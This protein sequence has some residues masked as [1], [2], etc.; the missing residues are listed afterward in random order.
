MAA[1]WASSRGCVAVSLAAPIYAHHVAHT[2]AFSSNLSG[3]TVINGKEVPILQQGGG[4]LHLGE[5]PI[6][7]TWHANYFLGADNQGRDVMARVL[8]GGRA[9]LLIGVGSALIAC[10]VALLF[11]LV[12][13]FFRGGVDMVIS[14][15]MDLIWAFPVFLLAI[16]LGL[17]RL[18]KNDH[19]QLRHGFVMYDALYAWSREAST[20]IHTWNPQ[21]G[22]A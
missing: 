7:P 15:M 17:S 5:I 18:F 20:E 22:A 14:R 9:S 10:T 4:V 6:G 8:Y 21:R 2:E 16:S 12:A 13:G 11:A 1:W 3:T 19:E